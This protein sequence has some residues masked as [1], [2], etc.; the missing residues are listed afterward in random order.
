MYTNIY[1]YIY[2]CIYIYMYIYICIYIYMHIHICIYIYIYMYIYSGYCFSPTTCDGMFE[3]SNEKLLQ[4]FPGFSTPLR[5]LAHSNEMEI[6]KNIYV[7]ILFFWILHCYAKTIV[8]QQKAYYRPR[9][10]LAR[11]HL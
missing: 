3:H 2:M 1:I 6:E 5:F 9:V 8:S 11:Y 10:V 7:E 4:I